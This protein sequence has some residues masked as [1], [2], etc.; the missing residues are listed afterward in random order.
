MA[1]EALSLSS[2]K[3]PT[4]CGA[5]EVNGES[6]FSYS[7]KQG[8]SPG[9]YPEGLHPLVKKWLD[10]MWKLHKEGK[11]KLP[12][13]HGKC[14][15]VQNISEYLNKI[16]PKGMFT[17]K[18]AEES[19]EGAVSHARQI[20]DVIKKDYTI[21]HKEFKKACNSCNPLLSD[22]NIKEYKIK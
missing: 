7:V 1:D 17:M 3:R 22:F 4:A 16:D 2:T 11:I 6:F 15:E 12:E 9:V 5:L 8:L 13:H 20:G 14:A 18:Q 10:K 19:F 21:L